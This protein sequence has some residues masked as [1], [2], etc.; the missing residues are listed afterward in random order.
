[1]QWGFA[2][3]SL[4]PSVALRASPSPEGVEEDRRESW[5]Q[6]EAEE[7]VKRGRRSGKRRNEASTEG[8]CLGDGQAG[9]GDLAGDWCS[10]RAKRASGRSG[11]S[12][13]ASMPASW[14]RAVFSSSAKAETPMMRGR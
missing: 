1:M 8:I 14:P 11:F 7:S 9:L 2:C 12:N 3:S 10:M 13:M 5:I 4:T 6:A